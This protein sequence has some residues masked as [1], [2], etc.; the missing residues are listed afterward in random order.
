MT[1]AKAKKT[2]AKKT[3]GKSRNLTQAV[4][5]LMRRAK[6]C[7][8]EEV[9]ALTKWKAVSMAQVSASSGGKL[10]IDDST[11]PFRYRLAVRP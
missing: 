4:V 3:N 6:G 11:R 8:R 2:T 9:L 5:A 7:T 10:R 1:K